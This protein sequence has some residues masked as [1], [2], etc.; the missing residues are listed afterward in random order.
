MGPGNGVLV[1]FSWAGSRA[2]SNS[3]GAEKK[4]I[5]IIICDDAPTFQR[6]DRGGRLENINA[7]RIAATPNGNHLD[8]TS[9]NG[10]VNREHN[11]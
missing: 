7:P 11:V 2:D 8:R 9:N 5:I 3:G 6:S 1:L 10:F 4:G